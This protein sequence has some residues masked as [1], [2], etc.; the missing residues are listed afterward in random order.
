MHEY[1][2]PK[3]LFIDIEKS[4]TPYHYTT[5]P[6]ISKLYFVIFAA[7]K[8]SMTLNLA[9]RSFKVIDLGTNSKARR[10]IHVYSY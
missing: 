3:W 5:E 2:V 8:E 7:F 10:P 6:P 4:R 9:Q 1:V